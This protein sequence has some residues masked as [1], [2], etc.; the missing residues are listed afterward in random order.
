MEL[1]E[2]ETPMEQMVEEHHLQSHLMEL[3]LVE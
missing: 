2:L 1:V 3:V